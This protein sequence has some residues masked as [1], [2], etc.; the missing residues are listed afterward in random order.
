MPFKKT[1]SLNLITS[2]VGKVGPV[3]AQVRMPL[4]LL[5]ESFNLAV[6]QVGKVD[7]V[8]ARVGMPLTL[9]CSS[10]LDYLNGEWHSSLGGDRVH[11]PY[12]RDY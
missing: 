2:Q 9:K 8:P 7:P 3:P 5:T 10:C 11:L 6:S 1:K 4:N 12:L